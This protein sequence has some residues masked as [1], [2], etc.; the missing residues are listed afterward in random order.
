MKAQSYHVTIQGLVDESWFA[1]F[2]GMTVIK[3]SSGVTRLSGEIAD[4]SALH[5][6][7]RKIRDLNITLISIQLL[8]ADGVT[9]VEC[10]YCR[11]NKPSNMSFGR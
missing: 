7:L 4:Q 8:E 5:G 10:R 9:P 1:C 3:E 11:M 6:L 2:T